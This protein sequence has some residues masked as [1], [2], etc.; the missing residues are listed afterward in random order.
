MGSR[1]TAT[2]NSIAV[3]GPDRSLLGIDIEHERPSLTRFSLELSGIMLPDRVA[4]SPLL[5]W[6]AGEAINKALRT[7]V[8]V[9]LGDLAAGRAVDAVRVEHP[10]QVVE[11]GGV[12]GESRSTP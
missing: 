5:T 2:A 4:M 3:V 12:V 9:M 6:V 1:G 11:A 7:P 8:R 10:H